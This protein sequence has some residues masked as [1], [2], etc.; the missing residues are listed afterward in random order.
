MTSITLA[1]RRAADRKIGH[2]EDVGPC[3]ATTQHD[4]RRNVPTRLPEM[5]ALG[6]AHLQL[7]GP[8]RRRAMI[9]SLAP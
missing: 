6:N 8:R 2:P 7:T 3:Y 9:A 5:R 1:A 4:W